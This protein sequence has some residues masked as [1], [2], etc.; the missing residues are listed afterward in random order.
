[1]FSVASINFKFHAKPLRR[2]EEGKDEVEEEE[3]RRGRGEL[4]YL[5]LSSCLSGNSRLSGFA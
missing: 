1:V 4:L 5:F 2:K 3:K